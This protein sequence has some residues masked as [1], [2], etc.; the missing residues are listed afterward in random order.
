MNKNSKINKSFQALLEHV[1]MNVWGAKGEYLSKTNLNQT[2]KALSWIRACYRFKGERGSSQPSKINYKFKKNRAGYLAAFGERHAYLPFL[3]LKGVE[4]IKSDAIPKPNGRRNELNITSLGAAAC[5]EL[6]GVCL[7]YLGAS[8]QHLNLK[9]N[10]IEKT[11]EWVP[12]RHVVLNSVLKEAFSKIET[13]PVDIDVDLKED[14]IIEFAKN[15]DRL[16]RTDILLIE[17]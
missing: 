2:R 12:N 10:S 7:F 9:L 1:L 8:Q 14:A 6:Y 16:A 17:L 3:Q 13:D 11:R 15:Y 4:T 5:V